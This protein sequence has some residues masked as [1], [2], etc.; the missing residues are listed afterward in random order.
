MISQTNEEPKN[1]AERKSICASPV[2][3]VEVSEKNWIEGDSGGRRVCALPKWNANGATYRAP[4][5]KCKP[6]G[7]AD[8][9]GDGSVTVLVKNPKSVEINNAL[10]IRCN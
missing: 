4:P 7:E 3:W 5:L 6:A 8:G 2:A 9:D 1:D 10:F